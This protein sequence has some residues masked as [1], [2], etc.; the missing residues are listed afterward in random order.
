MFERLSR[1]LWGFIHLRTTNFKEFMKVVRTEKCEVVTVEPEIV[2]EDTETDSATVG[3][4][5][6]FN[7]N[8]VHGATT[9]YGRPITY[10]EQVLHSFGSDLGLNDCEDRRQLEVE[11]IARANAR[12]ELLREMLPQAHVSLVNVT[13]VSDDA[14]KTSHVR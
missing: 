8:L 11:L 5:S 2:P 12:L 13:G 10:T 14:P 3:I 9:P 4:I 6:Y 1:W 7:Y